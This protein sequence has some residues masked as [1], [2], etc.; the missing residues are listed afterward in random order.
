MSRKPKHTHTQ[1]TH[2]LKSRIKIHIFRRFVALESSKQ[3]AMSVLT[4]HFTKTQIDME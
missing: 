2:S 1:R 4:V 3:N